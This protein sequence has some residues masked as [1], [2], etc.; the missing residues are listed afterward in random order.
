MKT[1]AA[2]SGVEFHAKAS[3]GMVAAILG[4]VVTEQPL[5]AVKDAAEK[6]NAAYRVLYRAMFEVDRSQQLAE[7]EA[8][9][10]ELTA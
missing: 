8:R 6:L 9:K 10:A 4:D 3:K 1:A 7:I 5:D 2:L